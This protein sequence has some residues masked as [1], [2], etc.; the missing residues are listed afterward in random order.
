MENLNPTAATTNR[1]ASRS[2]A[3]RI[4]ALSGSPGAGVTTVTRL[5][6]E[7]PGTLVVS[8][9]AFPRLT[10]EAESGPNSLNDEAL[11][12]F[13]CAKEKLERT[14]WVRPFHRRLLRLL[15][16]G[17]P[18]RLVITGLLTEIDVRYCKS[19]GARLIHLQAPADVRKLRIGVRFPERGLEAF[20]SLEKLVR[21]QPQLWDLILDTDEPYPSFVQS[22]RAQMGRL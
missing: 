10:L 22:L 7:E 12:E 3:I 2:R 5:L 18:A 21:S 9:S 13:R 8:M 1:P 15:R 20:E 6:T 14:C 17:L 16:R 4:L 11:A 19:I